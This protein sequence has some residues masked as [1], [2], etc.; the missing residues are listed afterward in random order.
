MLVT[1]REEALWE[2]N[3]LPACGWEGER[4]EEDQEEEARDTEDET[5]LQHSPR[6]PQRHTLQQIYIETE[7][8]TVPTRTA[9]HLVI[10][11]NIKFFSV[12]NV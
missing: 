2:G 8:L 9:S 5:L 11:L 6:P 1:W 4:E 10:C 7:E 12:L 3:V